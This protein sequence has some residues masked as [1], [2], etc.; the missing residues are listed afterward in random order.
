MSCANACPERAGMPVRS[1]SCDR[2][3]R[4]DAAG[5]DPKPWRSRPRRISEAYAAIDDTR[6]TVIIAYTIKGYGLPTDGHPQNHSSLLTVE[7]YRQLSETLGET[8]RVALAAVRNGHRRDRL[9]AAAAARLDR[10]P[11]PT[12]RCLAFRVTSAALRLASGTTQAALGRAL[13]DLTRVAPEAARRIVTVSPDVSSSTNLA[14]WI[15]KVGVWSPRS[16]STGSAT[17]PRRS[18]T[19]VSARPGSTSSWESRR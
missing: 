11:S 19:G 13:L 7:Q 2:C 4:R 6:P 1:R 9:C 16:G 5:C 17:T 3:R 8:R 14:G 15:N 12:P 10:D 18:C